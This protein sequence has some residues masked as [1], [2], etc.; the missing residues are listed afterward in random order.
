MI[1][2][3]KAAIF[4]M[5]GTILDSMYYW[6]LSGLEYILAHKM[7]MTDEIVGGVFKRGAGATVRMSYELAG[8]D[9]YEIDLPYISEKLVKYVHAHYLKEVSPKPHVIEFLEMLKNKGIRCCVA[10]ATDKKYAI[11]ALKVHGIDKYFEFVFDESDAGCNK[12]HAE[13]FE[14]VITRLGCTKEEC[15]LFED[16]MYSIRT[17]KEFGLKV[18]GIEDPCTVEGPEA[19]KALA[20]KYIRDYSELM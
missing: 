7:P 10:T 3:Y 4:D 1:S 14:K 12:A 20:D 2:G 11:N 5:D 16:A 18:V 19:V 8:R 13:Y 6:R 15:V 17:A 9:D